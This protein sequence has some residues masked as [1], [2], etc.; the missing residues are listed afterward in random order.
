MKKLASRWLVSLGLVVSV[1][2]G[3]AVTAVSAS[4]G[5]APIQGPVAT[6]LKLYRQELAAYNAQR[7]Q[8]EAN[9]RASVALAK[10]N[11]SKSL[12]SATTSAE[13]SAAQQTEVTAIIDAAATRS[14]ALIAL[15][16]PPTPPQ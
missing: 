13:R 8:I 7:T 6:S 12:A 4:A 1:A 10:S 3:T 11:F 2:L 5:N 16:N 9:F 15:G 14:A